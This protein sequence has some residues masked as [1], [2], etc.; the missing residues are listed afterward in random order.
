MV[1]SRFVVNAF[2]TM[3]YHIIGLPFLA[4][5]CRQLRPLRPSLKIDFGYSG[6]STNVE[7][8][9]LYSF[10][11]EAQHLDEGMGGV[12]S[13]YRVQFVFLIGLI[14]ILFGSNPYRG[15][16]NS[17]LALLSSNVSTRS[18]MKSPST[19]FSPML[20]ASEC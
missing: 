13:H 14:F 18:F 15:F 1:I 9:L 6:L 5:L 2:P 7:A 11:V 12:T 17:Q 20:L 16:A 4:G 3:L 10:L 19:S 8:C